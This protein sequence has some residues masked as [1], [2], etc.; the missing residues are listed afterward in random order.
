MKKMHCGLAVASLVL[1]CGLGAVHSP[2]ARGFWT[3]SGHAPNSLA[4][5]VPH[6]MASISFFF[7]CGGDGCPHPLCY[8]D[9][10]YPDPCC[11]GG[12][13]IILDVSGGGFSLTDAVHGVLFDISGSGKPVLIAWTAMGVDNAFLALPGSDGLVHNGKELFG[14]STAQPPSANPNGFAALA[15]YD[16]PANG[17][18][19]DGIIDARD[20]IFSSLRLWIDSNHDGICQPEELR[21]LSSLGV[22]SI[23]LSYRASMRRDQYGNLFRY[24]AT[25]NPGGQKDASGIGRIAYDVFL[26]TA[27]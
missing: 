6:T 27:N 10:D 21:T 11:C 20:K 8:C 18:N 15:V 17:G 16:Q 14:N 26:T 4:I 24:R 7:Q 12:S 23:S 9:P 25:V 5:G 19:G 3:V 1:F 2:S 22:D 13:P